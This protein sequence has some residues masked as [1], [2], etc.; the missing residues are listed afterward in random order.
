M[1]LPV[2]PTRGSVAAGL[3]IAAAISTALLVL[4]GPE[5]EIVL[6]GG[7]PAGNALAAIML[8]STAGAAV[9]LARRRS[10][11]KALSWAALAAAAAWLPV[12]VLMAGNPNLSF[13]NGLGE[14]WTALTLATLVL[15]LASLTLVLATALWRILKRE[16]PA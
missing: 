7:L 13:G 8:C 15:A 3:L 16:R 5:L 4:G 6:P 9:V 10:R 14:A 11:L 12:S 2:S 1:S